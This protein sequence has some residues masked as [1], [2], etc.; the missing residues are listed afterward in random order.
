MLSA[1][2]FANSDWAPGG[3]LIAS[4]N[5]RAAALTAAAE[6]AALPAAAAGLTLDTGL[7]VALAWP[8]A[9][10]NVGAGRRK[11]LGVGGD[12]FVNVVL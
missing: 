11:Q 4:L 2:L 1:A 7:S 10:A 3:R 8:A 5:L 9:A 12:L 6:S